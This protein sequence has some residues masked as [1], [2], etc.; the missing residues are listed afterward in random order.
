MTEYREGWAYPVAFPPRAPGD[1]AGRGARRRA[2]ARQLHVAET[3]K[4]AHVTYFFNGGREAGVGGRGA[5]PGRSPRDVPTYDLKPEMSA[6]RRADAF[7]RALGARTATASGSSTSPTPTWSATPASSRPRSRRSRR[8]TR[9]LGE[10]VAAVHAPGGACIVTADHGN[11]DDMLEPDGRPNTAHST[12][13]GAADRHRRRARRSRDGGILADV[14]PTALALLGIE[15]PGGMTG[16]LA[17]EADPAR[18][19]PTGSASRSTPA[20]APPGPGRSTP[21]TADRDARLRPARDQGRGQGAAGR[22]GRR[23]RLR[24]RP[25][26]HLPPDAGALL[27]VEDR[28]I[29][30][31]REQLR[32]LN[33]R[34]A[35]R[36]WWTWPSPG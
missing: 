33:E 8:S 20:T 17:A 14:A 11:A 19:T 16:A 9:C 7:C 29:G 25:R 1:D 21:R 36:P 2:A 26:Q 6:A 12:E 35:T 28:G 23:D 24:A 32:D 22:R 30:I 13:P 34:L 3:E 31:S 5:P 4:Y 10:V 18:R 27:S 15:Q